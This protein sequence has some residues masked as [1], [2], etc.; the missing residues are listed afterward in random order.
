M[1]DLNL[2]NRMS[3]CLDRGNGW[4]PHPK[5][6]GISGHESGQGESTHDDQ[7]P[8]Q[9]QNPMGAGGDVGPTVQSRVFAKRF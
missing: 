8:K 9:L 5:V 4:R 7:K 6:I 1:S 2:P 3:K